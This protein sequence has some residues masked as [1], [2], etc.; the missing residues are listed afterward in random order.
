MKRTAKDRKALRVDAVKAKRA[1]FSQV[2]REPQP[3]IWSIHMPAYCYTALCPEPG[4]QK[5]PEGVKR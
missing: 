5:L 4:L 3:D 1:D 2:L